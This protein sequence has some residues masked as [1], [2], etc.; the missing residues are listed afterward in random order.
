ML[1]V[2]FYWNVALAFALGHLTT[3]VARAADEHG[4]GDHG[5][6]GS[7]NLDIF[8]GALD[9]GIW[10]VVVFLVLLFVLSKYAWKPMLEGLKKRE[11]SI[12]GAVEEAKIARAETQRM[13]ADFQR[14]LDEA[15]QQIPQLMEEARRKAQELAEEM[16]VKANADIAAERQRL[17]REIDTA[18]DQALQ[19]IWNKAAD[20]AA[21]IAGKA[22]RR[23]LTEEDRRRLVEEAM[24]ELRVAG[25]ARIRER[26]TDGARS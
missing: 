7:P 12:K 1:R 6:G 13:Q 26:Q 4:T 16:R 21:D 20:I 5:K 17:R 19:T 23:S 11:E 2:R 14:K 22:I 3:G 9:L 8:A 24:N 18:T 15:H 25:E 10:T